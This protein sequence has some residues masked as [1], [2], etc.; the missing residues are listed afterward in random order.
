MIHIA[1]KYYLYN[2]I[3]FVTLKVCGQKVRDFNMKGCWY[4]K[5]RSDDIYTCDKK[6]ENLQINICTS[7]AGSFCI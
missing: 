5:L 4:E 6:K 2:R 3:I 1:L 7:I